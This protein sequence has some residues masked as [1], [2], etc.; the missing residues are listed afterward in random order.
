MVRRWQGPLWLGD[1]LEFPPAETAGDGGLLALGGDLSVERLLV[2][3]R[4]GIFPWP[5]YEN[6]PMFWWCP[7]PRFALYPDALHVP[8]SLEQR[9]RSG[10]FDVRLDTC[11]EEVIQGCARAPRPDDAGTWITPEMIDAYCELHRLGYAH[12]AE[13]W[14]DGEL[15]GGLYGVSLGG[16]FFGESMFYRVADASKVAFVR[17]VRQLV[18][19]GFGLV[20]CQLETAH[21]ARF[22]AQDVPRRRFLSELPDLLALPNRT[23]PWRFD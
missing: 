1:S 6:Q 9:V 18:A 10:R 20:D 17:L 22:G 14:L 21:L 13:S 12:C 19:W 8:K 4:R 2:A 7:D 11:F 23:G 3:Y 5:W 16:V 15:V